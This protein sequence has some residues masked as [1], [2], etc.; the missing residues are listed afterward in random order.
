MEKTHVSPLVYFQKQGNNGHKKWPKRSKQKLTKFFTKFGP[1][2]PNSKIGNL[3]VI[4]SRDRDI[5]PYYSKFIEPLC[6]CL[7]VRPIWSRITK[8]HNSVDC[9]NVIEIYG[10]LPNLQIAEKILVWLIDGFDN[11]FDYLLTKHRKER[12]KLKRKGVS[13]LPNGSPLML[14]SK[15]LRLA[16][17]DLQSYL[18]EELDSKKINPDFKQIDDHLINDRGIVLKK[19]KPKNDKTGITQGLSP[20]CSYKFLTIINGNSGLYKRKVSLRR[21]AIKKTS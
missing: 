10:P 11:Y 16:I 2:L 13:I 3:Y 1:P 18:I 21:K 19:I 4:H 14:S 7:G 5:N 15:K 8:S 6:Y 17:N 12:K 9:I 20:K